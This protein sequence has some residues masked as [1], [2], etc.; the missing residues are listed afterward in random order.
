MPAGSGLC[1]RRCQKRL[2]MP[3]NL[4]R[5]PWRLQEVWHLRSV[6]FVRIG[7]VEV[8]T[9]RSQLFPAVATPCFH[10]LITNQGSCLRSKLPTVLMRDQRIGEPNLFISRLRTLL[11][12]RGG[13][14]RKAI[15]VHTREESIPYVRC[16]LMW[17]SEPG[18]MRISGTHRVRARVKVFEC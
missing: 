7:W 3:V 17:L 6:Q 13:E 12:T 2:K 10:V 8:Q 16:N 4:V 14:V 1:L 15:N 5:N 11:L 9:I 18:A